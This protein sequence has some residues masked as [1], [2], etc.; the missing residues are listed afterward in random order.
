MARV[1]RLTVFPVKG[2]D[3]VDVEAARV[4]DGGTLE[5]DR[6]FA[7]FD[8]DGD[9]VNGKRTDRVHDLATDFDPESGALRVETPDGTVRRFDLEA[10]PARA[11]AWFSDFFDANLR[12]RRDESLGYV[13]RRD[14]GP[15]VVSTAT[16]EAVA[17]WFDGV[18]VDGARRRLRANVEVSGVP[19]FW[20]DR[21]VGEGAPAFEVAGVRV[22]GVTPCGRCVVPERDPDT[23]EP[24]PE[25]RERFVR[26]REAAFPE[27]AD[28]DA[29]DHYYSLMTIAR[30]PE[31]DRGETLRVGD[32]VAVRE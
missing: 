14:M 3:G 9:V 28:A 15:S 7:L 26:R 13:D 5:R 2:L 32:E 1:E 19:A 16:L 22:E 10:E 29:F 31:R 20:E 6:E 30:I 25:F 23:G 21:F 4:L 11:A 17:S 12:L 18:T 27:W 24:T 8:A